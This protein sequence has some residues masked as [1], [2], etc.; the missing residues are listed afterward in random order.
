MI[1]YAIIRLSYHNLIGYFKHQYRF[2]GKSLNP[3]T[4]KNRLM[5]VASLVTRIGARLESSF[6]PPIHGVPGPD[7]QVVFFLIFIL[8]V[9]LYPAPN[10]F[11]SSLLQDSLTQIIF[12]FYLRVSW[13]VL[14]WYES[15]YSFLVPTFCFLFPSFRT[16]PHVEIDWLVLG[17]RKTVADLP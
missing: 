3:I 10:I 16:H 12:F 6:P 7:K 1:A 2:D 11:V 8:V 13:I 15:V 14:S 9:W 5:Y 17:L 4:F